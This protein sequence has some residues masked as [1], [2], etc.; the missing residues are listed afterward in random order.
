LPPVWSHVMGN[1]FRD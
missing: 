1:I